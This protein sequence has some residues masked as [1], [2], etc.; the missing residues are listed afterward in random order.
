[1]LP[2]RHVLKLYTARRE[3]AARGD[4]VMRQST[5]MRAAGD[6]W[7]DVASARGLG[8]R[9]GDAGPLLYGDLASGGTLEIGLFETNYS[10]VYCTVATVRGRDEAA[11]KG[12]LSARPH[13]FGTRLLRIVTPQPELGAELLARYFFRSKPAG[14][15]EALLG[16]EARAVLLE[17]VDR[18]PRLFW[19]NG[20]STLVLEGVELVHER[21]E[22]IVA[23][24]DAIDAAGHG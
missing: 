4:R 24:L 20:T 13:D 9:S 1:M 19:E 3:E 23:A 17:Q 16:D 14:L 7:S 22:R 8:F 21:I 11:K 15:A 12:E 6:V 5:T 2:L 18:A 10:D